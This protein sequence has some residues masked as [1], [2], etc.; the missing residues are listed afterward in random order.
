[1]VETS[2]YLNS[3]SSEKPTH[4]CGIG[5]EFSPN[6][7]LKTQRLMQIGNAV[8][9]RG[10]AGAGIAVSDGETMHRITGNGLLD[11]SFTPEQ[12]SQIDIPSY[13]GMVHLR[14]PTNGADNDL[15]LQ[16]CVAETPEGEEVFVE[17]NGNM[18]AA[19]ELRQLLPYELPPDVSD[20]FIATQVLA[21]IPARDWDERVRMFAQIPQIRGSANNMFIGLKDKMFVLRDEN[22]IHDM[23]MG[24]SREGNIIIASETVAMQKIGARV[25]GTF[26][27]GGIMRIDRNGPVMLEEGLPGPGN[28]CIFENAYF[29]GPNSHFPTY[30]QEGDNMNPEEW[31]SIMNFRLKCGETVAEECPV[32]N[33]DF[34]VG[35]ADS[36]VPFATGLAVG[37]GKPYYPFMIRSHYN[38]RTFTQDS[39]MDKIPLL[40]KDKFLPVVDPRLWKGKNVVIG[41]DS[42]VR[43][44]TARVVTKMIR[45]LGVNEIHWRLGFPVVKYPCHL[46]ISFR[47]EKELL[48]N[49]CDGD[50]QKM[51][52]HI[53]ATSVGFISNEGI[54]R[55]GRHIGQNIVIPRNEKD[56]F[57][58]NGWCGGCVTGKFPV[59][60]QGNIFTYKK[61]ENGQVPIYLT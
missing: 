30:D 24:E 5:L 22:E 54:V 18:P 28:R 34:V 20:T 6:L 13:W 49:L 58:A 17:V 45:Q 12:T 48:A 31:M 40:V 53:G 10:Q 1:M 25:T 47:E 26:P 33:A 2:Q 44:N 7:T 50:W 3:E 21:K 14:Y 4:N 9:H 19:Q 55:A 32:P 27:R 38:G 29:S 15:N 59:D 52:D 60:K 61:E 8:Q 36:G 39:Q 41:D 56:I 46:A 43:G 11:H 51:A 35:M 57:L 37:M 23:V 16:P 42:L